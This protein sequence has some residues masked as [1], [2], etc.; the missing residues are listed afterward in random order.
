MRQPEMEMKFVTLG[1]DYMAAAKQGGCG[2]QAK[3][4][5]V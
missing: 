2:L 4:K 3:E 5:D 1:T